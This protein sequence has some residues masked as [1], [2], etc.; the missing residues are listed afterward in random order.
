[1]AQKGQFHKIP[2]KWAFLV[3][4]GAKMAKK[5]AAENWRVNR[6]AESRKTTFF[7]PGIDKGGPKSSDQSRE[8]SN[9]AFLIAN[10]AKKAENPPRRQRREIYFNLSLFLLF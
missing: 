9:R 6:S 8:P 1:M 4:N 5:M 2:P 3:A 7:F 10:G